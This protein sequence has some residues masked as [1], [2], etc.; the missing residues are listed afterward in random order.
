MMLGRA[1]RFRQLKETERCV[2]DNSRLNNI[3]AIFVDRLQDVTRL[4]LNLSLDW[5]VQVHTNLLRF[6]I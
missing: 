3:F 4:G 5:L 6:E 1:Y 2:P